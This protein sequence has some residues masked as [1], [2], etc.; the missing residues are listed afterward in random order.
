MNGEQRTAIVMQIE[1]DT[2]IETEI[3]LNTE[4]CK[5]LGRKKKFY[6]ENMTCKL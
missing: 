2:E 1:C 5:F 6:M 3:E 4:S